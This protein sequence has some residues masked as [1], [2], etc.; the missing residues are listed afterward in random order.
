MRVPVAAELLD[1][2]EA[3]MA[4]P[5]WA[6]SLT[7]IQRC[8]AEED[9]NALNGL[10]IGERDARLIEIREALFGRQLSACSV[11]PS[12]SARVEMD[13]Q[14]SDFRVP[15]GSVTR[16]ADFQRDEWRVHFRVPTADDLGVIAR[17]RGVGEMRHALLERCVLSVEQGGRTIDMNQLSADTLDAVV[18]QMSECDPQADVRFQLRCAECAHVWSEAFDITSYLWSELDA[19]SQRT[20]QDIHR[21][22]SAYGWRESDVLAVSP[23]RRSRY[24]EMIDS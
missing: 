4:Q 12:C 9:A 13:L 16:E 15:A 19:W 22:A 5:T 8:F 1:L 10:T 11:C 7:F 3:G 20:L 6:W 18:G 14:T 17:G 23:Q 2:W 21:L 24:L